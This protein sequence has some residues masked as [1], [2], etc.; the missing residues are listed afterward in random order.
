MI[1]IVL[2]CVV[3]LGVMLWMV[4]IVVVFLVCVVGLVVVFWFYFVFDM[5]CY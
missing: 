4:W 5:I 3:V 2:Y 1:W